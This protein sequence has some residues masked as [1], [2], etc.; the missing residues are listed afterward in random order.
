LSS[1]DAITTATHRI[2]TYVAHASPTSRH[3]WRVGPTSRRYP[4]NRGPHTW[5]E[6]IGA[7]AGRQHGVISLEQLR[8]IGLTRHR[9]EARLRAKRLYR[10]HRGVYAVGHQALTRKSHLIA[11]GYACGAGA[12]VSHRDAGALH[13][14]IGPG[15]Q[16]TE[17]TAQRGC[18]PK[19]GITVHR[20]RSLHPDDRTVVDG[21]PTT[22]VARTLIDLAEVLS[23]ERLAK[24]VHQAEVLRVFDL[25]GLEEA[26]ARVPGRKGRHRMRRVLVAHQPEPHLLRSRAER[27]LKALCRQNDLPQPQFNAWVAG[28]ELDVYWPRQRLALEFDGA[29][30]H[31]TRHAF[32]EDRRRDRALATEGIQVA[33]V[34]WPD[35]GPG[36]MAQVR[37]ILARR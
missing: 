12:L 17:V 8:A 7:A 26:L 32:H 37:E 31:H 9:I 20:S 19:P 11:A 18:K 24:A 28:Y 27:K 16:S 33:R 6:E 10:L 23:E 15:S 14:L 5:D 36:L 34:T 22:S 29:A 30:T 13:G 3:P 2:V 4:G 25:R 1:A 21:I 35:L